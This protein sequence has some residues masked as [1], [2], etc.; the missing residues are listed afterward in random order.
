MI[1]SVA[2]AYILLLSVYSY[3]GC[4]KSSWTGGSVPLLCLPLHISGQS[5]N[6]SNGP[7]SSSA[8]VKRVLLKRP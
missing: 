4:F 8:M 5:M 6:F 7:H 3:E 2:Q 1:I